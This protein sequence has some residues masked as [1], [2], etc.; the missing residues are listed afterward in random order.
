MELLS[1]VC[2]TL[3]VYGVGDEG[4]EVGMLTPHSANSFM[5]HGL[6]ESMFLE[7][8]IFP[9]GAAFLILARELVLPSSMGG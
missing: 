4:G 8:T 6:V 7:S 9:V 5:K 1:V 3:R 2:C